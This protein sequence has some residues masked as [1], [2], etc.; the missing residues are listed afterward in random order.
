M[1]TKRLMSGFAFAAVAA[2]G[3]AAQAKTAATT[4]AATDLK[5]VDVPGFAGVHVAPAEGDPA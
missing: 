5:W 2:L 3:F 1:L 4:T